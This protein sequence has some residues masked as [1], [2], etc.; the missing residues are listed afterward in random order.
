V[1][2][3]G[4]HIL[5]PQAPGFILRFADMLA[6][7]PEALPGIAFVEDLLEEGKEGKGA[8]EDKETADQHANRP[9]AGK[10]HSQRIEQHEKRAQRQ[11][12]GQIEREIDAQAQ[13]FE[14]GRHE[15]EQEVIADIAGRE[16]RVFG[17][18]VIAKRERADHRQMRAKI[19]PD[20][21]ADF[22]L[23]SDHDH[24]VKGD[25]TRHQQSGQRVELF[26]TIAAGKTL[27]GLANFLTQT[28]NLPS[29][30]P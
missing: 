6:H 30:Q 20:R 27:S 26:Q 5:R 22:Q 24:G 21:E 16:M 2:L 12:A 7:V 18:E 11:E 17:G 1:A 8:A 28:G 19:A 14:R 29:G 4:V 23:M 25:K 9:L 13:R 15:L 10:M 3:I